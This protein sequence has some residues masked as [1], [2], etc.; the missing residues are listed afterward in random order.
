MLL[1]LLL[2][3]LFYASEPCSG[4]GI[5]ILYVYFRCYVPRWTVMAGDI[6]TLRHAERCYVTRAGESG[7]FMIVLMQLLV[8]ALRI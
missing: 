6:L 4:D 8:A 7:V 5:L 3:L 2:L 1:L